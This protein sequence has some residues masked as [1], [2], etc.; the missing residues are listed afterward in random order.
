MFI[1]LFPIISPI[2]FILIVTVLGFI[3]PGYTHIN[4]TIS[5]LAIEKYGW[6]QSLNFFQLAISFSMLG[7]T[8]SSDV[9]ASS[10]IALR[11]IFSLTSL[12]LIIAGLFPTDRIENIPLRFSIY[13]PLGLI[14]AGS[15]VL[16]VLVSPFGIR[17]LTEIL[18]EEPR[19]NKYAFMTK[20]M[21]YLV[22]TGSMIWF[23]CF[24]LGIGLEYRGITQ[25]LLIFVVLIWS[26]IMGIASRKFARVR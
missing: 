17:R 18:A 10:R 15:I 12:V 3:T 16:F 5:R 4:Y 6:I 14:H 24:I 2:I 19:Y 25:K 21:G 20:T 8:L 9:K 11:L 23:G 26:I 7:T 13:T 22:F 1:T